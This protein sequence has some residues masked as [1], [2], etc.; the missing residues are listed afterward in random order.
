ME[1]LEAR[2]VTAVVTVTPGVPPPF[3]GRFRYLLLDVIDLPAELAVDET[4]ILLHPPLSLVGV[5]IVMERG[6]QQN[7]SLADG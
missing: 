2:G 4:V 6:C 3:P 1:E 5:L 7:D